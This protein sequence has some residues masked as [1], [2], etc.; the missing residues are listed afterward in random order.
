MLAQGMLHG[1]SMRRVLTGG[2]S[3]V[4]VMVHFAPLLSHIAATEARVD[5][6]T[7]CRNSCCLLRTS[8]VKF[9]HLGIIFT[10]KIRCENSSN[11]LG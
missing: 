1:A 7:V 6:T 2:A 11:R 4:R 3:C 8:T 9:T 5:S 10:L